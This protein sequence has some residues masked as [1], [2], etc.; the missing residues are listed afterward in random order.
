MK[1]RLYNIIRSTFVLGLCLLS[2]FY[3]QALSGAE[4][5]DYLKQIKPI[6]AEKCYACHSALKQ[7]SELRLET[8]DLMLRGGDTDTA[9]V[10]GKIDESLLLQRVIAKSDE[11]M[12]PPGEGSRLSNHEIELI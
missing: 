4:T 7:E 2:V 9:I 11:Q 8:R 6:F 1:Q 10:P 3:S 5:V 12:P